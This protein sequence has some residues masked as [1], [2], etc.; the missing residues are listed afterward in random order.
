MKKIVFFNTKGGTGKTT[1]CYNY[2][3]YLAEKRDKKILFIDLDPQTNLVQAFNKG[4]SNVRGNNLDKL[5]VNYI[6]GI[7]INFRDY[8]MKINDNIDL[9]PSSN[10]ISLVEEYLTDYLLERTFSESKIYKSMHRSII[11]KKILE[12]NIADGSYDYVIIDS[13]PNFTL[14]STTSIIYAKNII[15]VVKP[16]L[17]SYLD[18]NYLN[19]VIK[20]LE[21]KFEIEAKIFVVIINAFEKIKKTSKEVIY[22]IEKKYGDKLSIID[23]KIRYLVAFQKSIFLNREPVFMAYPNS[24]ATKDVLKAFTQIDEL[25]DNII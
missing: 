25:E 23:Q 20:N 3:W 5:I 12:E 19:K 24:E 14:L 1:L 4:P 10:N 6:K 7:N 11:I 21:K 17:F 15:V 16:E 2:G 8:V 9:L 18:I 13:Q 22:S